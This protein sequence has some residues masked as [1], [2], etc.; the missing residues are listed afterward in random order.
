MA[1]QNVTRRQALSLPLLF[2]P[3]ACNRQKGKTIGMVPMGR[4]HVFWQSIHAG[5]VKASRETGVGVEWNGPATE[6]DISTQIQIMDAMINKRVDA[7]GVAPIDR[8]A[9]V[10]VIER[11]AKSSIPVIVFDS[12]V[13]TDAYLT[14]I[15]TDNHK[16][17]EIAADRV[18]Q[19]TGGQGEVAIVAATAGS[20][21]TM[22]RERGFAERIRNYPGIKVVDKRYGD[23]EFAKS[24][25]VAENLLTA[26]PGLRAMFASNEPA[27]V[28]SAQA[29]TARNAKVRI[30]GFDAGP[31]LEADLRARRVDALVV[32]H[33]FQMGYDTVQS[34]HRHT[35]GEGLPKTQSIQPKLVT[36]EN[37]DSPEVQSQINPDL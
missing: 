24:M 6:S 21:S 36:L 31:T 13:D 8:R 14:Q 17:G 25:R 33:P 32:Q 27:T 18:A 29:V 34:F 30:V 19:I 5:A 1:R 15:A 23:S 11:A 4:A 28:G 35:R 9:L 22:A 16:G 10:A 26:W 12:P 37:I 3:A 7:I 2:L 20:A